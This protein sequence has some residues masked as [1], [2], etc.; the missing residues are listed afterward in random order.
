MV[1]S[2]RVIINYSKWHFTQSPPL[3]I[4]EKSAQISPI[5]PRPNHSERSLNSIQVTN[6]Y[7]L[8]AL[9]KQPIGQSEK[10]TKRT[11]FTNYVKGA[12]ITKNPLKFDGAQFA[13]RNEREFTSI[14]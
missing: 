3:D 2:Q 5:G 8:S 6:F 13:H 1:I 9:P 4:K 12:Y 14:A 7:A 11:Y 10:D